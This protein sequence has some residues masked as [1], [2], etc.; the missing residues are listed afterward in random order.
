M[1]IEKL[2]QSLQKKNDSIAQIKDKINEEETKRLEY[3][4]ILNL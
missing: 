3:V 4:Q 2:G 1:V